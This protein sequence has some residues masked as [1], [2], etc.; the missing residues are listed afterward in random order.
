MTE[1]LRLDIPIL[2]P[3][4]T[5]AAD[6][7]VDRLMS[8]M[9][10]REGVEDAHVVASRDGQAAQLCIHF[11]PEIMPL[12]RIRELVT[13]AG[14]D[15]SERFGHATWRLDIQHERRAR[16][17]AERLRA[18]P[19][20]LEAEAS[21]AGIVRVE[22][23]RSAASEASLAREL[24]RMRIGA[25]AQTSLRADEHAGHEHPPAKHG[26][27]EPGHDHEGGPLG[28]NAELTFALTCGGLLAAGY[29]TE[30]ARCQACGYLDEAGISCDVH[31][32]ANGAKISLSRE[33]LI[34]LLAQA[35]NVG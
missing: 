32:A 16:T 33:E 6:R 18:L 26:A 30:K 21:V 29:L 4:V 35:T 14:A 27:G 19:G 7:C 23:D 28:G 11:D 1:K 22:F 9:R 15:I 17:I 34:E 24:N 31:D 12:A 10:G 20:V 3:E 2:L 8:E 13:A 25:V 5:D